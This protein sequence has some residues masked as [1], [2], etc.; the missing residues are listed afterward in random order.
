MTVAD[1]KQQKE[2]KKSLNE[3][4]LLSERS[5][6]YDPN[7]DKDDCIEDLRGVQKDNPDMFISRNFYR[8]NGA[9]SDKTWD[10]Y[11]GT[12]EEFRKQAGL[13][14]TRAQQQLEKH[15]AKHASLDNYKTFFEEEVKPWCGKYEKPFKESRR[16]RTMVIGADFHDIEADEFVLSVFIATCKRIQPDIIV[17]AGDIY[18]EYEFSRY[19]KDPR[20]VNI[21]ERYDFVR[22][23]IFRALRLA[24]PNA[25]IDFLIGN[26]E[27][28]I[29]KHLADKSPNMR[30]LLDLMGF[31]F[32]KLLALDEFKINLVSKIDLT[33]YKPTE[34]R[35]EI[36]N[37]YK[38]YFNTLVVNHESDEDY[39]M[40]SVNAHTHRP[41]MHT[42]FSEAKGA[43]W[44][45][46]IGCIAKVDAEYHTQKVNAANSFAVVTIDTVEERAVPE[47]VL[48]AENFVTVG[49]VYYTRSE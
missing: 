24:C 3:L 31:T 12:F 16:F 35:K 46:N 38:K 4:A 41:K 30:A 25:Q 26:H 44:S 8:V 32:E 40:C 19:D 5:K 49:G 20:Q 48:F 37:N 9:Y 1:S 18:D 17:L 6:K 29:M 34:I 13:Q 21:K 39:G 23:R 47:H 28:R 11:F 15:I 27:M 7:A 10:Q 42:K 33:A 45:L 36:K 14:L 2:K 43:I 22:E